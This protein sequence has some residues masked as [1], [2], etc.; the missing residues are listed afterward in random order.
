MNRDTLAGQWK[1]LKGAVK[2]RWARL[3]DD[4]VLRA[5]GNIDQLAGSIQV[6]YGYS[7]ERAQEEIESWMRSVDD[8]DTLRRAR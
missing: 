5:E 6:R 2:E 7:R 4:D 3:T 1:Q 8:G